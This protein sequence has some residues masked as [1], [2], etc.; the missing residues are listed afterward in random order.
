MASKKLYRLESSARGPEGGPWPRLPLRHLLGG[1]EAETGRGEALFEWFQKHFQP[2]FNPF[3]PIFDGFFTISATFHGSSYD[4][5]GILIAKRRR[6]CWR[7][8]SPC[9]WRLRRSTF[10]RR[11]IGCRISSKWPSGRLATAESCFLWRSASFHLRS[12]YVI[13]LLS[14]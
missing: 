4:S 11:A 6:R 5:H 10:R 12:I 7:K 13:I 1:G 9:S 3:S 14:S 8:T 2:V